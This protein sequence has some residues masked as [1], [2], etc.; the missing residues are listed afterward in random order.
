MKA[1][2]KGTKE[3]AVKEHVNMTAKDESVIS[4]ALP[5]KLKDLSNFT[6]S[7]NIIDV[8]ILHV[9]CDLGSSIN[10]MPLKTVKKLKVGE[11]TPNNMTLTLVDSCVTQLVGI[12]HDVLVHVDGLVFPT[13]FVVLDTKGASGGYFIQGKP[14]LAAKRGPIEFSRGASIW[15]GV[16]SCKRNVVGPYGLT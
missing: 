7:C 8:N 10:V 16:A 2:I 11:I 1:L 12:L 6:I 9:L 4:K 14:F 5:P 13:D 3:K 15:R